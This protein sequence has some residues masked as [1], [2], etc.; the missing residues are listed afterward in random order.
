MESKQNFH[1]FSFLFLS[2]L[3]IGYFR[4][5]DFWEDGAGESTVVALHVLDL[6]DV[7]D[8][9]IAHVQGNVSALALRA[10]TNILFFLRVHIFSDVSCVYKA[11]CY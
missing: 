8:C 7:L 2:V 11:S 3:I 9:R 10:Y 4:F 6:A 1:R 5:R